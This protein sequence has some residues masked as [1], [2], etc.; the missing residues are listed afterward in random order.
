MRNSAKFLFVV[1]LVLMA[2]APASPSEDKLVLAEGGKPRM[3]I[4]IPAGGHREKVEPLAAMLAGHLERMIGSPIPVIP[5]SELGRPSVQDGRIVPEPGKAATASSSFIVLGESE[6]TRLL[7]IGTEGLGRGGIR[8]KTIGNT[9]VL[10]GTDDGARSPGGQAY[11]VYQF[12][13][14]L[15]CRALWPGESGKV[16]PRRP[17]LELPP[18]DISYT[19][20]L[21]ER[22]IRFTG[23]DKPPLRFD[24]GLAWLG[25]PPEQG[26]KTLATNAALDA[27]WR[28]WQ[29]L[30]GELGLAGGHN[31][32][33]LGRDGW[34]KY[35]KLHPEWFA[36]Q[37]GGSRDQTGAKDRWRLCVSNPDLLEFVAQKLIRGN[38][39]TPSACV[40]LSPNDGGNSGFCMCPA[41]KALDPT[42]APKVSV[43][44]FPKAGST[45][46]TNLLYP[47]LSDRYVWY[48]NQIAER[49]TRELPKLTFLV[50]A[51]SCYSTP[52]VREKLHPSLVLRYIP[53]DTSGWLGWQ[54]AGARTI[55]WRP[56][57]LYFGSEEGTLNCFVAPDLADTMSYLID[58]AMVA[59]DMDACLDNWA[60]MGLNYYTAAR[61]NWNPRLK[62][63]D[64]LKDYCAAFGAAAGP[65]NQ[66]FR[67]VEALRDPVTK[68]ATPDMLSRYTPEALE[69]LRGLLVAADTAAGDDSALKARIAFLRAGLEYTAATAEAAR[70]RAQAQTGRPLDQAVVNRVMDRRRQ[71]MREL[72]TREPLAINAPYI[73][74]N[75]GYIWRDLKWKAL[76]SAV[77]QPAQKEE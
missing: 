60:T 2:A 49:V 42:N 47:S 15:G 20:P 5:L 8:I 34:E 24:E 12:L 68:E 57:T 11:A 43:R 65:I 9:A 41:C 62:F 63:K 22:H 38:R 75:G 55:Y 71:F 44:T 1:F 26:R 7:K 53:S 17:T 13:E 36:L 18:L 31:G 23:P 19:P 70:L 21:G 37:T 69:E 58:H 45:K 4:V 30:G 73:A 32:A 59:T 61:M 29:C 6:L 51:Y 54:Q 16:I 28:E 39:D 40:S 66:Y 64:I 56:N 33:G 48:W 35:G 14:M 25:I 50:D 77:A 76:D 46:R 3:A 72:A 27:Q 67:R 52:P 10:L 74:A